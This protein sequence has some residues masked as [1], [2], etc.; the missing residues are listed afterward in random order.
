[1][2]INLN[3]AVFGSFTLYSAG[4]VNVSIAPGPSDC[5]NLLMSG[6]KSSF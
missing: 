4:I 3:T 5:F 2:E 6:V 1:M